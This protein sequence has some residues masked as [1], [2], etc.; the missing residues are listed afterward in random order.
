MNELQSLLLSLRD[1]VRI[2]HIFFHYFFFGFAADILLLVE[3][4]QNSINLQCHPG[5]PSVVHPF[6][7]TFMFLPF[8][9][10]K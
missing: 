5:T 10:F 1:V 7:S 3:S 8:R 9:H 4:Y 6:I 2:I